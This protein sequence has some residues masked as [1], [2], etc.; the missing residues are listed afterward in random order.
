MSSG[1]AEF[2]PPGAVSSLS[3]DMKLGQDLFHQSG[4]F[5]SHFRLAGASSVIMITEAAIP[6]Y[7]FLSSSH[8]I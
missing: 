4:C 2:E 8:L 6:S 1:A 5:Q 7:C 3:F